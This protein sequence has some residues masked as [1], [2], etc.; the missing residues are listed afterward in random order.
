MAQVLVTAAQYAKDPISDT[1]VTIKAT[2]G[3]NEVH[4]PMPKT[5]DGV[6]VTDNRHTQG[7]LDWVSAGNSIT[8]A[9]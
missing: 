7:V 1:N 4:C 5:V 2:I 3:G 8:A 6:V 9:D